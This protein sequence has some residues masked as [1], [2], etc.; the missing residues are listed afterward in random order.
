MRGRTEGGGRGGRRRRGR[1]GLFLTLTNFT[2]DAGRVLGR[3][4]ACPPL[5][6]FR[7]TAV[8]PKLK[9]T[10]ALAGHSLVTVWNSG[11]P[12]RTETAEGSRSWRAPLGLRAVVEP[13][14]FPMTRCGLATRLHRASSDPLRRSWGPC[15]MR[16]RENGGPRDDPAAHPG[17]RRRATLTPRLTSPFRWARVLENMAARTPKDFPKE[18]L[19]AQ[20]LVEPLIPRSRPKKM[21]LG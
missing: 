20:Y 4:S 19:L 7:H 18:H 13:S 21:G 10:R 5:S 15:Q 17:S 1:V 8:L 6:I 14:M 11:S 12:T 3:G 16:P 2:R 9:K